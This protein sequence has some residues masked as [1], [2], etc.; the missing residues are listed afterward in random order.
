MKF[1]LKSIFNFLFVF[2]LF[3]MSSEVDALK[4]SFNNSEIKIIGN[5]YKYTN[6][7]I[8]DIAEW[9]SKQ[10]IDISSVKS[11][12]IPGSTILRARVLHDVDGIEKFENL[13]NFSIDCLSNAEE[14]V[15]KLSR[16]RKLKNISI[17]FVCTD[18]FDY[19]VLYNKVFQIPILIND[20]QEVSKILGKVINID[21]LEK[22]RLGNIFFRYRGLTIIDEIKS[23]GIK[24]E[25]I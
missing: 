3:T 7:A 19:Y 4:V 11:I 21:K 12:N 5:N 23:K 25:Y 20:N 9:I 14:N 2:T 24:V 10:N 13:E 1:I 18:E 17:K 8:N 22:L 15:I 16:C 6:I